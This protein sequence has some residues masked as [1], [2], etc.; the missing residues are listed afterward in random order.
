[1]YPKKIDRKGTDRITKVA[2]PGDHD[3]DSPPFKSCKPYQSNISPTDVVKD[4]IPLKHI[5]HGD[6][7]P[8]LALSYSRGDTTKVTRYADG[9]QLY[10]NKPCKELYLEVEDLDIPWSD[11]VLKERIGAGMYISSKLVPFRN[12]KMNFILM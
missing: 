10:P 12:A 4:P 7:Q 5:P 6:G 1:M 11:L 3:E 8:S 2:W 9:G